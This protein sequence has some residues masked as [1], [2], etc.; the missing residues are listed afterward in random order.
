[1]KKFTVI[2]KKWL[3][4][5]NGN[6]YHSVR[7]TRHKDGKTIAQGLTYGYSDHYRHTA[8]ILMKESGWIKFPENNLHLYERENDYPII[9]EV[10]EGLKR[11]CTENGKA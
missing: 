2:A 1:M 11:D 9:W 6:T 10:S 8:L 3:D 4:K 7:I 5:I